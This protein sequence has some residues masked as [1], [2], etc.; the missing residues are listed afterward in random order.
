MNMVSNFYNVLSKTANTRPYLLGNDK[1]VWFAMTETYGFIISFK[2]ELREEEEYD[3]DYYELEFEE[4]RERR[5]MSDDELEA[6]PSL[7]HT[8]YIQLYTTEI[9]GCREGENI[10]DFRPQ[11]ISKTLYTLLR[12]LYTLD[13]NLVIDYELHTNEGFEDWGSMCSVGEY[14]NYLFLIYIKCSD[15]QLLTA[16]ELLRSVNNSP[17]IVSKYVA[18]EY[19]AL[20]KFS[21]SK[22]INILNTNTK[23]RRLGYLKLLGKYFIKYPQSPYSQFYKRY[24]SFVIPY[25]RQLTESIN[26][27]GIVSAN[28]KGAANGSSARPYIELANSLG[29]VNALNKVATASKDFKVYVEILGNQKPVSEN[30]FLLE[31]F[32]KLFFGENI[33][34]KD[35]FYISILLEII[36]IRHTTSFN[37]IKEVFQGVL[38]ERLKYFQQGYH[39]FRDKKVIENIKRIE[40]RISSWEK[41][42]RYLEHVLMPRLNW[43]ADLHLVQLPKA[44]KREVTVS[45]TAKGNTFFECICDWYDLKFDW[46][47]NPD[48]FMDSY[49]PHIFA[50]TFNIPPK[51]DLTE[52]SIKDF[53]LDQINAC[54]DIFRTM[55]ANRV[56]LSQTVSYV[57]GKVLIELGIPISKK[58]LDN[59]IQNEFKDLFVYKF[60]L[61]FNDGYLQKVKN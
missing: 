24:E 36:Y 3:D 29:F 52:Q 13:K 58:Y 16:V 61:Q 40:E 48:E 20:K 41:P 21:D 38:I 60:Q 42:E 27:R 55:A 50:T 2:V 39:D 47:I 1:E 7:F 22:R 49:F 4:Q 19:I 12:E 56:T 5:Y 43:L 59:V 45:I 11:S 17:P 28:I 44:R 18:E 9:Y 25:Q 33:L 26:S 31:L 37:D 10:E 57:Q 32:D 54:F 14:F 34:G 23:T 46:I 51:N 15:N 53:I 30:P 35:F 6:L 8:N